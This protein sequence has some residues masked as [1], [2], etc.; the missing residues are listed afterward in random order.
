M[1]EW[2]W[3]E[4]GR[5]EKA[6]PPAREAVLREESRGAAHGALLLST[7]NQRHAGLR[8]LEA[9]RATGPRL[10]LGRPHPSLHS[11]VPAAP[12]PT[13]SP[14]AGG[15]APAHGARCCAP[16]Q[17]LHTVSKR[18]AR[19]AAAAWRWQGRGDGSG[20]RPAPAPGTPGIPTRL[21]LPDVTAQARHQQ[22]RLR[23]RETRPA[24]PSSAGASKI[25]TSAVSCLL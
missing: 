13:A 8:A 15:E 19:K 7:R 17:A 2:I 16:F 5:E 20:E 24:P 25:G 12:L 23:R 1:L 18:P 4:A 9:N 21:C 14:G 10:A 22:T 6:N 11:A 3:R